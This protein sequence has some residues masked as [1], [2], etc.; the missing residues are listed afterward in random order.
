MLVDIYSKKKESMHD[1]LEAPKTE[2]GALHFL[3]F[4]HKHG[5]KKIITR[6]A[7]T[8][9]CTDHQHLGDAKTALCT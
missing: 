9:V 7:N 3:V 6:F 4:K 5:L 1:R 8:E 2:G